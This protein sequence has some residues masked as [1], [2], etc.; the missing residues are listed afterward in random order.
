V[1]SGAI[2]DADFVSEGAPKIV[3]WGEGLA[4]RSLASLW[5]P[6]NWDE[7]GDDELAF[8]LP[9]L[10][11][12]RPPRAGAAAKSH[13]GPV[14]YL[15]RVLRS[16]ALSAATLICG[17]HGQSRVPSLRQGLELLVSRGILT[18]ITM[19]DCLGSTEI[20][21]VC[22]PRAQADAWV[23][24]RANR[25]RKH[26]ADALPDWLVIELTGLAHLDRLLRDA[27]GET[28]R[29]DE[30]MPP[31]VDWPLS[32]AD[33]VLATIN[34]RLNGAYVH[35][36]YAYAHELLTAAAILGHLVQRRAVHLPSAVAQS[37]ADLLSR[38]K[39]APARE[40]DWCASILEA[41][42]DLAGGAQRMLMLAR[43]AATRDGTYLARP[44]RPIAPHDFGRTTWNAR[45]LQ[46]VAQRW[47]VFA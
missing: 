4:D 7:V 8:L 17:G 25:V 9:S 32:L 38:S 36:R 44:R 29:H 31:L 12:W 18:A 47:H 6:A 26:E 39:K 22:S 34:G 19:Q 3:V 37:L 10:S 1:V 23:H 21:D 41:Y 45:L 35:P 27:L 11:S 16:R 2:T 20:D 14:G 43:R 15:T 46:R 42:A 28:A 24:E 40:D 33:V 5:Y 30:R 13:D